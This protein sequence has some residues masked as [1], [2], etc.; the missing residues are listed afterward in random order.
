M[1]VAIDVRPLQ[2][3]IKT[4]V[5]EYAFELLSALFV[6]FP[7]HQFYVCS[8]GRQKFELPQQWHLPHIIPLHVST[9]NKGLN[10]KIF[11]T[12]APRLSDWPR[13]LGKD[14]SFDVIY[15]P[16]L[17]FI[18]PEPEVPTI[19]TVHDL[20]FQVFPQYFSWYQRLWHW[21]IK[22]RHLITQATQITT[23]SMATRLAVNKEYAVPLEKISVVSPGLCSDWTEPSSSQ[24]AYVKN[25]YGLPTNFIL[26]VAT[27][28]PRKNQI[29]LIKAFTAWQKSTQIE[30][31]LV[32][33]GAPGWHNRAINR[34]MSQTARVKKIGFVSEADKPALYA[35]AKIFA[36]P[37]FYEGFGLPLLEAMRAGVPVITSNCSAMPEAVEKAAFLV[38]PDKISDTVAALQI[39]WNDI[40]LQE[41]YRAAGFAQIKKFVW[42]ESAQTLMCIL[43]QAVANKK[44]A[45]A[46]K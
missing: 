21:A 13:L 17:N 26:N 16:N 36:Y 40:A 44:T 41:K 30:A 22:P 28:E 43:E 34:L 18:A 46:V 8:S 1:R 10:T 2:T 7:E 4:G 31:Q 3:V 20:S 9:P 25:K 29:G 5:G 37:S 39:L 12:A 32:I 35:L 14:F 33:A 23:P 24:M 38:D 15:F 19:L 11:F 42:S 27:I 6:Q 45:H